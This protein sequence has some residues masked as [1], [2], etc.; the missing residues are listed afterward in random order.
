[1]E[2]LMNDVLE[3]GALDDV[4]EEV[5]NSD[6]SGLA[7]GVVIGIGLVLV[8]GLV[9]KKALKPVGGWIKGKIDEK[10]SKSKED[11]NN[12]NEVNEE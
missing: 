7:T 1:M 6:K 10:R 11:S 9:Y 4:V 12:G 5:T 8:G 2:E 3:E